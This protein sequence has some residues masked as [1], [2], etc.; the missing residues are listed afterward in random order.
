MDNLNSYKE[1]YTTND[2]IKLLAK[3]RNGGTPVVIEPSLIVKVFLGSVLVVSPTYSTGNGVRGSITHKYKTIASAE[4]DAQSG[5][6]I[7]VTEMVNNEANL[8][9]DGLTYHFLP[10]AGISN[11][12]V[13]GRIFNDNGKTN[14]GANPLFFKITGHGDFTS[15]TEYS[16]VWGGT[17]YLYEG[18][19]VEFEFRSS[20][21]L[22]LDG[23]KADVGF[24]FWCQA[25][26]INGAGAGKMATLKG[27][28]ERDLT[29]GHYFLGAHSGNCNIDVGGNVDVSA[30]FVQ[31]E[32]CQL[33]DL[34][35]DGKIT[36]GY[37]TTQSFKYF[38]SFDRV[39]FF[40]GNVDT[41]SGTNTHKVTA[42]R[43]EWVNSGAAQTVNFNI[44]NV[45]EYH[46][47]TGTHD[48]N[49]IDINVD[50]ML[51][52]A[53][54]QATQR[55]VFRFNNNNSATYTRLKLDKC[56]L[57]VEDGF[58]LFN[59]SS[60]NEKAYVDMMFQDCSVDYKHDSLGASAVLMPTRYV[61]FHIINSRFKVSA[62]GVTDGYILLDDSTNTDKNVQID[63]VVTNAVIPTA[64][65]NY[66]T[67]I[68]S[69]STGIRSGVTD[70]RIV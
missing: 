68:S 65:L 47:G 39:P 63:N 55:A 58:P 67:A 10:G 31:A 46:D 38:A 34:N 48:L 14:S 41:I 18:S 21:I 43:V 35:V 69:N 42:K 33:I 3:Y 7:I 49:Y 1:L 59:I 28:V 9:K 19:S 26:Y 50:E 52:K 12:T 11:T 60:N 54:D 37:S 15:R 45:L 40:T 8:G 51:I 27:R 62:Q 4:A 2:A 16:A 66:G 53:G 61:M 29:G 22:N 25:E 32:G 13:T 44:I 36:C 64:L 6:T 5:D 20:T 30:I 56:K 17:V 70:V 23:S 57:T 24:H